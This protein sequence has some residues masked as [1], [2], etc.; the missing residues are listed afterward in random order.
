MARW[1]QQYLGYQSF[2][3]ALTSLEI[4]RF[5]T[6]TSDELEAI[7][8]RRTAP[9]RIAFALQLGFLKM[10]GRSLNSV[11]IVP[12]SIFET[13]GERI[14]CVVPRIASIRA[15]Y[16]RRRTLFDHQAAA[17]HLLGRCEAGEHAE[18][19]LTTYLRREAIGVY[20]IQDLVHR[21]RVWLIEHDYVLPGDR[22]IRRLTVRSLRFQ[23]K[24][25]VR[26]ITDA[27]EKA[28][29]AKWSAALLAPAPQGERS[30]ME[31]LLAAPIS[32]SI[33]ALDDQLA[34]INLLRSLG[35]EGLGL[36]VIPLVG[37]EHFS[38]QLM[39]R[40]PAA[41][42]SIR[43]P[44]RTL[45]LACFIRLQLMRLTDT[46]LVLVDH[47]I[48][49]HW[50]EAKE[51]AI[52][53]QRGRLTR[54]RGLLGD[55]TQLADD[56]ALDADALRAKLRSLIAPFEPEL[57]NTQILA[58]RRELAER[59]SELA[60][61]LTAARTIELDTPDGHA[62]KTAFTTLDAAPGKDAELPVKAANPFG[63]SWQGL[64]DQPDRAAAL[65]CYRAATVMLLKRALKNRS[66]TVSSSLAYK[67]PET[68]L[69]PK[70]L[71]E[72]DRSR[73]LRGLSLPVTAEKYLTRLDRH[74][75]DG[76]AILAK[77]IEAGEASID[78]VGVKLP[79]RQAAP[80]DADVENAR[81]SVARSYGAPQL[82]DIIIDVDAQTRFSWALLG[83]APRS[84]NELI[85]LYAALLALGSDLTVADLVR[86]VPTLDT[87]VLG[88]MVLRLESEPRL[89]AAND[90]VVRFMRKHRV[91]SLWGPGLCASADMV[92]LDATRRLWN[93]RLDPRRKGPAIGT[94][95][96]ILDQWSIFYDQPIVLNR[97]QAGAA[98]EGA[99]RQTTVEKLDRVAVDT[100]GFTH[101]AMTVSK[102][103][104][105][106][107]CPH[108]A[109]LKTRKL[110]LPR[111]FK[112]HVPDVLKP[113][114]APERISRRAV[115][116][117]WDGLL[118]LAVSV[119]DGWYPAT[120][121]LEQYGSAAQGDVVYDAGVGIGKLLR[122]IYLCDYLGIASFRT[123]IL[124]LQNQGEAVHSL[125]RAIHDGAITA[126]WGRT[127]HQMTAISGALTL[128]TNIVMA[129]NTSRIQAHLDINT[130]SIPDRLASKVAPIGYAHV[131]MR[132][133]ISFELGDA[134]RRLL[135]LIE[136]QNGSKV[137]LV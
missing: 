45:E 71:W 115:A 24:A 88:Q 4:D 70:S 107:L 60:R 109:H 53:N 59:S 113:I 52:D 125:Q 9:N 28:T 91:A 108:L 20:N 105:F 94:Y 136:P 114:I 51:G 1:D 100:H 82:S 75:E 62:L 25:L 7:S 123:G 122:T 132:G 111:G 55:L 38:R 95:P 35:A 63:R 64:I 46:A 49:F 41:L 26:S 58:I 83:R 19:A 10:T 129:W 89:R 29:R 137:E 97:R 16:R 31:W 34:K 11:E 72:R 2:P 61:L 128:L 3:E 77:A 85:T 32:K 67:A 5:F 78:K 14:G 36:D 126:K 18:R 22:V 69:I 121:A 42:S 57:G 104:G 56:Q 30:T 37:L 76:L 127:P 86:M 65:K 96:H 130:D 118:R 90:E 27:T 120:D 43:E 44:R 21:A 106:D 68:R 54:F 116:K 112:G 47:L 87:D 40:K 74:L 8:I 119:K 79:K 131:N 6:P 15:L 102:F 12:V 84:E 48:A 101:F 23:E 99:L 73:Y 103:V 80:K 33:K 117:G 66:V 50:R 39:M 124:D 81:R 92:S 93:A 17:R 13:I 98:I 134:K 110:F 135:G 133:I